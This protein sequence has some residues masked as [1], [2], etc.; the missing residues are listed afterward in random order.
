[1]NAFESVSKGLLPNF[2]LSKFKQIN[3]LL[4]PLKSSK[5]LRFSSDFR[6]SR[7]LLIRLN[8]F[9]V[10]NKLTAFF[11]LMIQRLN[12]IFQFKWMCFI[13]FLSGERWENANVNNLTV[14]LDFCRNNGFLNDPLPHRHPVFPYLLLY[15]NMNGF[16]QSCATENLFYSRRCRA[17]EAF[18]DG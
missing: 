5:N 18:E 16:C 7:S 14:E 1:M 6:C 13:N 15:C 3:Q 10:R 12:F 2:I 11:V 17:C 4:F 9:N 8:S